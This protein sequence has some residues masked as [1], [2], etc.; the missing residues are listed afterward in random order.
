MGEE[1]EKTREKNRNG[2]T[3]TKTK[4]EAKSG[5]Q[6]DR[7]RIRETGTEQ[8]R[9]RIWRQTQ[10]QRYQVGNMTGTDEVKSH[11]SNESKASAPPATH[12]A[13]PCVPADEDALLG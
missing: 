10:R 2:E 3:G 7:D 12:P 13:G 5:G 9:N 1:T 4:T 11:L 6:R 8:E